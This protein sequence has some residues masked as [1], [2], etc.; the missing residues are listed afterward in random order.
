VI[1][2]TFLVDN[3]DDEEEVSQNDRQNDRQNL[4]RSSINQPIE[5]PIV[6]QAY[7]GNSHSKT[8]TNV[9]NG[10][11]LD[12]QNENASTAQGRHAV[13]STSLSN[14]R[15]NRATTKRIVFPSDRSDVF[16]DVRFNDVSDRRHYRF[17]RQPKV[18]FLPPLNS[19]YDDW[20][21]LTG[22]FYAITFIRMTLSIMTI[23]L[24]GW[25]LMC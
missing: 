24:C 20:I 14:N 12:R 13:S 7:Q 19:Y 2:E 11:Q 10:R 18:S 3:D 23:S 5:A 9:Q 4:H 16:D 6:R 21:P 17:G 25:V 8:P 22:T 15:Q 1:K